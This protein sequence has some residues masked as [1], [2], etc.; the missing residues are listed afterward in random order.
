MT[1]YW[2]RGTDPA[3]IL[4]HKWLPNNRKDGICLFDQ[5]NI[6]L[7]VW[8]ERRGFLDKNGGIKYSDDKTKMV[9][10]EESAFKRNAKL[11]SG[12]LFIDLVYP[13]DKVDEKMIIA[14]NAEIKVGKYNNSNDYK[15]LGRNIYNLLFDKISALTYTLKYKFGQFWI[16]DFPHWNG[17]T[18][19]LGHYFS[20]LQAEC[21][22][23]GI[24][25]K[26]IPNH[27]IITIAVKMVDEK[28]FLELISE[29]DWQS[30]KKKNFLKR[31]PAY[32]YLVKSI[33]LRDNGELRDAYIDACITLELV[34]S[35]L[36]IKFTNEKLKCFFDM[37]RK[38]Q[39]CVIANLVLKKFPK[40]IITNACKAIDKRNDIIHE[41]Y[42]PKNSDEKYYS[43]L[44]EVIK[45]LLD[46]D[47]KTPRK[48]IGQIVW[49]KLK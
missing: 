48:N 2:S 31:N 24:W 14:R 23:D 3:G 39:L 47:I 5:E 29:S 33:H 26:F 20:M 9:D 43:S 15:A 19:S 46:C 7:N 16:D 13:V 34:M 44:I 42:K 49:P 6:K 12:P 10:L 45:E 37:P 36:F 8:F 38:A 32:E 25:Y 40:S 28:E 1:D 27:P 22:I 4:F 41:G 11:E 21:S 17:A 30:L 35:S 18:D